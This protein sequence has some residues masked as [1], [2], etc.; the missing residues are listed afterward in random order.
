MKSEMEAADCKSGWLGI[1]LMEKGHEEEK[2]IFRPPRLDRAPEK[3]HFEHVLAEFQ[4]FMW[5][6]KLSSYMGFRAGSN[7][8]WP[9]TRLH[10]DEIESLS[11]EYCEEDGDE[12]V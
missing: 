8:D 2:R 10:E 1:P 7:T 3:R 12:G 9:L 4:A 11:F 6:G 5:N